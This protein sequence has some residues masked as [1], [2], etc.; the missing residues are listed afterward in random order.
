M[1][2]AILVSYRPTQKNESLIFSP[3]LKYMF[4]FWIAYATYSIAAKYLLAFMDGWHLLLWL[5]LGK[6]CCFCHLFLGL[7]NLDMSRS[8]FIIEAYPCYQS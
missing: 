8:D 2:S 3:A 7:E 5:S 6:I 1:L 4:V